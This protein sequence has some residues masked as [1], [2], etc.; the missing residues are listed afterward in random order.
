MPPDGQKS[1]F[2]NMVMNRSEDGV[3][4]PID[5]LHAEL[6]VTNN[7]TSL[8]KPL[9]NQSAS[10]N[11]SK[12]RKSRVFGQGKSAQDQQKQQQQRQQQQQQQ[13]RQQQ[14]QQQQEEAR[15]WF[16]N[17]F[18]KFYGAGVGEPNGYQYSIAQDPQTR[19]RQ[20]RI[21]QDPNDV[22]RSFVFVEQPNGVWELRSGTGQ[23]IVGNVHYDPKQRRFFALGV[24]EDD[25][26]KTLQQSGTGQQ[27][28]QQPQQSEGSQRNTN[29]ALPSGVTTSFPLADGSIFTVSVDGMA[30]VLRPLGNNQWAV[31][32]ERPL[33]ELLNPQQSSA[34]PAQPTAEAQ[35][36]EQ[37]PS[38]ML[39]LMTLFLLMG[40][41]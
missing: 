21:F 27:Q 41:R 12:R 24:S 34:T 14:Q 38:W 9:L 29:G 20:I 1:F 18:Q 30:R 40:R 25:I 4:H 26:L 11:G 22:A 19:L 15:T 7:A 13:Q 16:A 37:I 23:P 36:S 28:K 10:S 5:R 17:V 3:V 8:P 35:S 33:Q 31:V 6:G 2:W 39:L 32:M